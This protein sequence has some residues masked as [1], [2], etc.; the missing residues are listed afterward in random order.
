MYTDGY[1]PDDDAPPHR[2]GP[3][4]GY[5]T[6]YLD[7]S[8]LE[9]ATSH[10]VPLEQLGTAKHNEQVHIRET[11]AKFAGNGS[12]AQPSTECTQ[13]EFNCQTCGGKS[14]AIIAEQ[15]KMFDDLYRAGLG[16]A[17]DAMDI[18][19]CQIRH[20]DAVAAQTYPDPR[21]K[22]AAVAWAIAHTA[23]DGSARYPTDGQLDLLALCTPVIMRLVA[24][25]EQAGKPR[26]GCWNAS[27]RGN[28]PE[29]ECPIVEAI[30]PKVEWWASSKFSLSK[31]YSGIR[32][33]LSKIHIVEITCISPIV[34]RE[35]GSSC[36]RPTVKTPQG[37]RPRCT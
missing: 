33:S 31:I 21:E 36:M 5:T 7:E 29:R 14:R 16:A 3:T 12:A 22:V 10:N 17:A 15:E 4:D 19:L 27:T 32:F 2:D 20:A 30:D 23:A 11:A 8:H 18:S 24:E 1:G 9:A 37:P 6:P 35:F 13:H 25:Y 34:C 26:G 28:G